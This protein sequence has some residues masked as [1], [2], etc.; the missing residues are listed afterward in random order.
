MN[1]TS[2]ILIPT[3]RKGQNG[4]L[5]SALTEH[6]Q[7]SK[8]LLFVPENMANTEINPG[9]MLGLRNDVQRSLHKLN[10]GVHKN[11]KVASIVMDGSVTRQRSIGRNIIEGLKLVQFHELHA[12]IG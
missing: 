5:E 4:P 7:T 2:L 10:L 1:G 11:H 3:P 8:R 6:G 9:H 12:D